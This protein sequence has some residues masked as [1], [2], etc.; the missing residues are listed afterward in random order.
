MTTKELLLA[1]IQERRKYLNIS[2]Q[3]LAE[4]LGISQG[5][6]SSLISGRSE[7]SLDRFINICDILGLNI[8]I[9]GVEELS[10]EQRLKII[11]EILLLANNLKIN[12]KKSKKGFK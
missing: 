5:Q 2:Q 3:E 7:I 10:E 1:T 8:N 11:D 6:Y 4:Q 9:T 12:N